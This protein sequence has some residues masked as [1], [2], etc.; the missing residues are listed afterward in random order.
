MNDVICGGPGADRLSGGT[1][2]DRL[3]GQADGVYPDSHCSHAGGYVAGD[4]LMPGPG[5]DHVDGGYDA[6]QLEACFNQPDTVR[7]GLPGPASAQSW[8]TPAPGGWCSARGA[9]SSSGSPCWP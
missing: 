3:Y 9:T 8:R 7:Y 2:S 6:R 1:G 4:L 5:N